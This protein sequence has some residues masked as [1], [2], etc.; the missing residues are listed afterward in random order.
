[1]AGVPAGQKMRDFVSGV[2]QGS[3]DLSILTHNIIRK[4]YLDHAGLK[5]LS[6]QEKEQLK[7]LVEE[8]LLQMKV[9]QPPSNVELRTEAQDSI[10]H[11]RPI[12]ISHSS[13]DEIENE[14]KQKRQM[15][16]KKLEVSSDE[17]DSGIDSKNR[18]CHGSPELTIFLDSSD[19]QDS[20]A[21]NHSTESESDEETTRSKRK[22]SLQEARWER[23][24]GRKSPESQGIGG[25]QKRR[26][27]ESEEIIIDAGQS[28]LEEEVKIYRKVGRGNC[29]KQRDEKNL[30]KGGTDLSEVEEISG[31]KRE[32]SES[33]NEE[34]KSLSTNKAQQRMGPGT[35]KDSEGNESEDTS[36][37]GPDEKFNLQKK[38]ADSQCRRKSRVVE[39]LGSSSEDSANQCPGKKEG[40]KRARGESGNQQTE[41]HSKPKRQPKDTGWGEKMQREDLLRKKVEEVKE[42]I[43]RIQDSASEESESESREHKSSEEK[44]KWVQDPTS[45][46]GESQSEMN[47]GQSR[48]AAPISLLSESESN[49]N[50]DGDPGRTLEKKNKDVSGS[51]SSQGEEELKK[52]AAQK[53]Q[54]ESMDQ[55]IFVLS[56]E[57]L[58]SEFKG[59]KRIQSQQQRRTKKRQRGSATKEKPGERSSLVGDEPT[60]SQQHLHHR[61]D[62]KHHS[63]KN[64]EHPF[65]QR[66]KRYIRECGVHRNYKKLLAG[67]H[68]RKAQIKALRE[69]LGSLGIKGPPSLAKCKALKQKRE[70]A[71]EMASLDINNIIATEGRPKRRKVWSL[72]NNPQESPSSPEELTFRRHTTDWSQLQ[73]VISSDG[74]SS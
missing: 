37:S 47:Q 43:Q 19:Q 74:E 70:A 42:T 15:I 66:L 13:E 54:R 20:G 22:P 28:D 12:Y 52:R 59:K 48:E 55:E 33:E 34:K 50:K 21:G 72:Y 16:E 25:S 5:K 30:S 41:N 7:H 36:G 62:K 71:A 4:K 31:K 46:E 39:D 26:V 67:C 27:N 65:I 40:A 3:P 44:K 2:F 69:E 18:L 45:G 51:D 73:G 10:N 58:E 1:M 9:D 60:T 49:E 56:S 64:E 32:W 68:S 8:E 17:M 24:Q 63:G 11:N 23:G 6:K 29:L 35:Q 57:D 38:M 53:S 61:K 14:K